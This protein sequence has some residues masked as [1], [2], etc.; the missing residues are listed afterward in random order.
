MNV[1]NTYV[2][3]GTYR[4]FLFT[5]HNVFL[6][7]ELINYCPSVLWHCWLGYLTYKIIPDVIYNVFGGTLNPTQSII[8]H[9]MQKTSDRKWI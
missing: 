6:P 7:G 9:L 3:S 2:L 4:I 1:K 5:G 8:M